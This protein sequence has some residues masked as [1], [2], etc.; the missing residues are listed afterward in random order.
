MLYDSQIKVPVKNLVSW[1]I[2]TQ[3]RPQDRVRRELWGRVSIE[4][5]FKK[6]VAGKSPH[7]NSTF[8]YTILFVINGVVS[9]VFICRLLFLQSTLSKADTLGTR[10][11]VRLRESSCK[12]IPEH[13]N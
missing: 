13:Q 5:H 3:N 10:F 2:I 1:N 4:R 6:R 9:F 11:T 8:V 7:Y 12:L